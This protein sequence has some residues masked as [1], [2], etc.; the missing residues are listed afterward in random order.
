MNFE[1]G[2]ISAS[3]PSIGGVCACA[4]PNPP[5]TSSAASVRIANRLI[6]RLLSGDHPRLGSLHRPP[7]AIV[8]RR[9]GRL[10]PS[11]LEPPPERPPPP[12][13]VH[14]APHP[15]THPR[16]VGAAEPRRPDHPPPQPA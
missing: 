11:R 16:Q 3:S 12:A 8:S 7:P 13:P 14:R 6:A 9:P 15:P 1:T 4:A 5:A 2:V 10:V